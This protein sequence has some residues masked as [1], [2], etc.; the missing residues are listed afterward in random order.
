MTVDTIAAWLIE[1]FSYNYYEE[2][3]V[4]MMWRISLTGFESLQFSPGHVYPPISLTMV[5]LSPLRSRLEERL[6]YIAK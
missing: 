3:D 5:F 4:E 1:Y 2:L 6:K